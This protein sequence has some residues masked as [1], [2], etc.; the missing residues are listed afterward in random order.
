MEIVHQFAEALDQ[1]DY[2]T[3][4]RLLEPDATYQRDMDLIRGA[5]AI[6]D[7]F[8][9]VSE[10]GRRNLDA[11]EYYHEIDDEGSPLEISFIDILRSEGDALEIRHSVH[12]A[13]AKSGLIGQLLF[14]RPPGEKEI[15]DEFFQRHQLQPP[16]RPAS[17]SD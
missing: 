14:V 7:S 10:W 16:G 4:L 5:P 15:L 12:L 6:V 2:D 13:I 1:D 17:L 3:A 8:R 11:L 9:A